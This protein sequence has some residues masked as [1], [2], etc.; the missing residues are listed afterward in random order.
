MISVIEVN[1]DCNNNNA[2]R[3]AN[4]YNDIITITNNTNLCINFI[5]SN[6]TLAAILA[7]IVTLLSALSLATFQRAIQWVASIATT[8]Q[9]GTLRQIKPYMKTVN[10]IIDRILQGAKIEVTTTT[11]LLMA[12]VIVLL[13]F[14]LEGSEKPKNYKIVEKP[15]K[16]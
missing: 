15:K 4:D 9:K 16:Q 3:Y 1:K 12:I 13:T 11:I 6:L 10:T 5:A 2:N 8:P 14:V 7:P